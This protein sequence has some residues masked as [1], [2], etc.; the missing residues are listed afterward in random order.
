MNRK[1]IILVSI[2][3]CTA[4]AI[5]IATLLTAILLY[6]HIKI[7]ITT[8]NKKT[9]KDALINGEPI[10]ELMLLAEESKL[11]LGDVYNGLT[12]IQKEK[13]AKNL[14]GIN[15]T[16]SKNS[17]IKSRNINDDLN[18]IKDTSKISSDLMHKTYMQSFIQTSDI[19]N[20]EALLQGF[21][22]LVDTQEIS[23]LQSSS[24]EIK[25]QM[26]THLGE[27]KELQSIK[28]PTKENNQTQIML[29]STKLFYNTLRHTLT[30][31]LDTERTEYA[32][33]NKASLENETPPNNETTPSKGETPPNNETSPSEGET[34]PNNETTPSKGETPPNNETTPSKGETPPNNE[35]SPSEGETPPN[36]ETTPSKGETPPNNETSPSEGETPPNNETS[37]LKGKTTLDDYTP[38]HKLL[39]TANVNSNNI[40]IIFKIFFPDNYDKILK[41]LSSSRADVPAITKAEYLEINNQIPTDIIAGLYPT[42]KDDIIK[43]LQFL[44]QD[45]KDKELLSEMVVKLLKNCNIMS[46]PAIIEIITESGLDKDP[47]AAGII[48]CRIIGYLTDNANGRNNPKNTPRMYLVAVSRLLNRRSTKELDINEPVTYED[49]CKMLQNYRST[50]I[51]AEVFTD[52]LI[53]LI[54]K[55]LA[56]KQPL[57]NTSAKTKQ[58]NSSRKSE[59][60]SQK[61][62]H[63]AITMTIKLLKRPHIND[64]NIEALKEITK[65]FY[66]FASESE[67]IE[68]FISIIEAVFHS[69]INQDIILRDSNNARDS[70]NADEIS[71]SLEHLEHL[72]IDL[73]DRNTTEELF[74]HLL[75]LLFVCPTNSAKLNKIKE[76]I[77]KNQVTLIF[78]FTAL[79]QNKLSYDSVRRKEEITLPV[80]MDQ[81][82]QQ[83]IEILSQ[84]DP[85]F[86]LDLLFGILRTLPKNTSEILEENQIVLILFQVMKQAILKPETLVKNNKKNIRTSNI[87]AYIIDRLSNSIHEEI[88]NNEISSGNQYL[89]M[90]LLPLEDRLNLLGNIGSMMRRDKECKSYNAILENTIISIASHIGYRT[91]DPDI[92]ELLKIDK[93]NDVNDVNAVND[94]ND[95]NA[96]NDIIQAIIFLLN[97]HTKS[98]QE[99]GVDTSKNYL[100]PKKSLYILML[101]CAHTLTESANINM[102]AG[103]IADNNANPY[104]DSLKGYDTI[105]KV[106]KYEVIYELIREESLKKQFKGIYSYPSKLMPK[107]ITDLK[108]HK[109]TRDIIGKILTEFIKESTAY[110]IKWIHTLIKEHT[111]NHKTEILLQSILKTIINSGS[112]TDE[113]IDNISSLIKAC[114]TSVQE[115]LFSY[116]IAEINK[117]HLDSNLHYITKIISIFVEQNEKF[118]IDQFKKNIQTQ[119]NTETPDEIANNSTLYSC[120]ISLPIT[121]VA[122][123]IDPDILTANHLCS[124][125]FTEY[126]NDCKRNIALTGTVLMPNTDASNDLFK[127]KELFLILNDKTSSLLTSKVD[128][129]TTD[130]KQ[131][132]NQ[133]TQQ[134][135]EALFRL[136]ELAKGSNKDQTLE[137]INTNYIIIQLYTI[138]PNHDCSYELLYSIIKISNEFLEKTLLIPACKE[139]INNADKDSQITYKEQIILKIFD[140]IKNS[141][142]QANEK[143]KLYSLFFDLW[144]N[145]KD[146]Q[147]KKLIIKLA[148]ENNISSYLKNNESTGNRIRKLLIKESL[149]LCIEYT[150]KDEEDTKRQAKQFVQCITKIIIPAQEP[151]T[152]LETPSIQLDKTSNCLEDYKMLAITNFAGHYIL[153]T[154]RF[155][156]TPSYNAINFLK[157]SS[158]ELSECT[159]IDNP[160]KKLDPKTRHD[161]AES[162]LLNQFHTAEELSESLEFI[163]EHLLY[164]DE[165]VQL[166]TAN[167]SML[168][169]LIKAL[170]AYKIDIKDFMNV[171]KKRFSTGINLPDDISAQF[172]KFES[173]IP[174]NDPTLRNRL[175]SLSPQDNVTQLNTN[176]SVEST[177]ETT[178]EVVHAT[179]ANIEDHHHNM[180]RKIDDSSLISDTNMLSSFLK[181]ILYGDKYNKEYESYQD[182][183]SRDK[184]STMMNQAYLEF[185]IEILHTREINTVA[186]EQITVLV[187][188]K[189]IQYIVE[190]LKKNGIPHYTGLMEIK[191]LFPNII[192]Y[193]Y[194]KN[195]QPRITLYLNNCEITEHHTQGM[196]SSACDIV[197]EQQHKHWY[198]QNKS[199]YYNL[200]RLLFNALGIDS[201]EL[202]QSFRQEL[203]EADNTIPITDITVILQ[204]LLDRND[205]DSLTND[206]IAILRQFICS[207]STSK[208]EIK[209][210][211]QAMLIQY[212]QYTQK[213]YVI[214]RENGPQ[215]QKTCHRLKHVSHLIRHH[216]VSGSNISNPNNP[217]SYY[218]LAQEQSSHRV[219]DISKKNA[220]DSKDGSSKDGHY[221][222]SLSDKASGLISTRINTIF[223]NKKRSNDP[224][225][226]SAL[227]RIMCSFY[228]E[229][230]VYA[231]ASI[232]N[233]LSNFFR[234][235]SEPQTSLQ[236]LSSS[237]T[238]TM[239]DF[240]G[241][242]FEK[243]SGELQVM[244][245]LH[246]EDSILKII[247]DLHNQVGN[248]EKYRYAWTKGNISNEL[249]KSFASR[250][251]S[252]FLCVK[253]C[254]KIE[255][256][257]ISGNYLIHAIAALGLEHFMD[258]MIYELTLELISGI[259]QRYVSDCQHLNHYNIESVQELNEKLISNTGNKSLLRPKELSSIATKV[260]EWR[261]HN[262]VPRSPFKTHNILVKSILH[263]I[264]ENA[265][266]IDTDTITIEGKCYKVDNFFENRYGYKVID[267]LR[268]LP[269]GMLVGLLS[270]ISKYGYCANEVKKYYI[271][272]L[273]CFL[274]QLTDSYINLYQDPLTRVAYIKLIPER[275]RC[276]YQ[277]ITEKLSEQL[278]ILEL[279]PF[280]ECRDKKK[281][282]TIQNYIDHQTKQMR[283]SLLEQQKRKRV[284]ALKN[285]KIAII[286][287]LQENPDSSGL[288]TSNLR[289]L[290][291]KKQ[292]ALKTANIA[293]IIEYTVNKEPLSSQSKY[294]LTVEDLDR[295]RHA[296]YF[297]D[298]PESTIKAISTILDH[299]NKHR[300]IFFCQLRTCIDKRND[301]E[302]PQMQSRNMSFLLSH[303]TYD[304]VLKV[305]KG[306]NPRLSRMWF[307]FFEKVLASKTHSRDFVRYLNKFIG[308]ITIVE[309]CTNIK[310]EEDSS[311][312]EK[313]KELMQSIL[314]NSVEHG[315]AILEDSLE[316]IKQFQSRIPEEKANVLY[317]QV[318]L[319]LTDPIVERR[320]DGT[321]YISK[322][323]SHAMSKKIFIVHKDMALKLSDLYRSHSQDGVPTT[324]NLIGLAEGEITVNQTHIKEFKFN[325]AQHEL[326]GEYY[327]TALKAMFLRYTGSIIHVTKVL[328]FFDLFSILSQENHQ[329]LCDKLFSG[330]QPLPD[331]MKEWQ[332]RYLH[333]KIM[334]PGDNLIN[335]QMLF[336]FT[337]LIVLIIANN[338]RLYHLNNDFILSESFLLK[339][340]LLLPVQQEAIMKHLERKLLNDP[341]MTL[342]YI[343]NLLDT[344]TNRDY[345]HH[346]YDTQEEA[347][348]KERSVE[349][350]QSELEIEEGSFDKELQQKQI[351]NHIK[352]FIWK[353]PENSVQH[354]VEVIT[355]KS[356]C[357]KIS[358][359]LNMVILKKPIEVLNILAMIKKS[360]LQYPQ[361]LDFIEKTI[362]AILIRREI[363]RCGVITVA[364]QERLDAKIKELNKLIDEESGNRGVNFTE[365][366][367]LNDL[368][369][370]TRVYSENTLN[371]KSPKDLIYW[372]LIYDAHNSI[373]VDSN[374]S[375]RISD[376][377]LRTFFTRALQDKQNSIS[378]DL[379]ANGRY[380]AEK[381][382]MIAFLKSLVNITAEHEPENQETQ[383][384]F[385]FGGGFGGGLGS[386]EIQDNEPQ[387]LKATELLIKNASYIVRDTEEVSKD[388]SPKLESIEDAN[389]TID[390]F[391]TIDAKTLSKE[392]HDPLHKMY[393]Q[394]HDYY[395]QEEIYK[396]DS[397]ALKNKIE[398]I[399]EKL[400]KC[401]K[402]PLQIEITKAQTALQIKLKVLQD[403]EKKALDAVKEPKED[404]TLFQQISDIKNEYA[405]KQ[406][407]AQE[408][409]RQHL[410]K[411]SSNSLDGE[412]KL[413][414]QIQMLACMI[415]WLHSKS[416]LPIPIKLRVEQVLEILYTLSTGNVSN[417]ISQVSTG[418]GKSAIIAVLSAI[419]ALGG[420]KIFNITNNNTLAIEGAINFTEFFTS[421]GL[422]VSSIDSIKETSSYDGDIVYTSMDLFIGDAM[423]DHNG[424]NKL[425][426][427]FN[428]SEDTKPA[429][430]IIDEYDEV[431]IDKDHHSCSRLSVSSHD[432]KLS[433]GKKAV[434][435]ALIKFVISRHYSDYVNENYSILASKGHGTLPE[436]LNADQKEIAKGILQQGF[437]TE[438]SMHD[439]LK[440]WCTL[441]A[442]NDQEAIEELKSM[443][444]DQLAHLLKAAHRALLLRRNY[445]YVITKSNS[446]TQDSTS[447]EDEILHKICVISQRGRMDIRSTFSL[448]VHSMLSIIVNMTA[449]NTFNVEVMEE[450]PVIDITTAQ[451][452]L[453]QILSKGNSRMNCFSGTI[454]KSSETTGLRGSLNVDFT[455]IT[456]RHYEPQLQESPVIIESDNQSAMEKIY[457]IAR[458]EIENGNSVLI[459]SHSIEL[460]SYIERF[461]RTRSINTLSITDTE[462]TKELSKAQT[463]LQAIKSLES[464]PQVLSATRAIGRGTDIKMRDGMQL[465]VINT[466]IMLS[467][468][469]EKQ[470]KGRTARN[471]RQGKY[472]CVFSIEE[473]DSCNKDL[474][475][476][477][478][479]I[480]RDANIK[481]E[482]MISDKGTNKETQQSLLKKRDASIQD[483]INKLM[484]GIHQQMSLNTD[485][486]NTNVYAITQEFT[487]EYLVKYQELRIN[488]VN[489]ISSATD[490]SCCV[491]DVSELKTL[492]ERLD[493]FINKC[494]NDVQIIINIASTD[495]CDAL[496]NKVKA[497]F[498]EHQETFLQLNDDFG[499]IM[500]NTP[501]LSNSKANS[502]DPE[503][504]PPA[505]NTH[506]SI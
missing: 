499:S 32:E 413:S 324:N 337:R 100:T 87:R 241:L 175:L 308:F 378:C 286:L 258:Y 405:K 281:H 262:I 476:K 470:L 233:N 483:K 166:D 151:R 325:R 409:H 121:I 91:H 236:E 490:V 152:N 163:N 309:H 268:S 275:Y 33:A 216:N 138:V 287:A 448:S 202:L 374:E 329:S 333:N 27:N 158:K 149:E 167:E 140:F 198:D 298:S 288:S 34:P 344:L 193:Y 196:S 449:G 248:Y 217:L 238:S 137:I 369:Q 218:S 36:N 206:N 497:Q 224:L 439:A 312:A 345:F 386:S 72:L 83:T 461:L 97:N 105:T 452:T 418:E 111:N 159:K 118:I 340:I 64:P 347:E 444:K 142:V 9:L 410:L 181:K 303:P 18:T 426:K 441:S 162:I 501:H 1:I 311:K 456:P 259:K 125:C 188:Q 132:K 390:K 304:N 283:D 120:I 53:R 195:G 349:K 427:Y 348:L 314:N 484:Q 273:D 479:S 370:D 11:E 330:N 341:E 342:D 406:L 371:I 14:L 200:Y 179:T 194:R 26:V 373:E 178:V 367:T 92:R 469:E 473:L 184:A 85:V 38:V 372:S 494:I 212:T 265:K 472:C 164:Q 425:L 115:N 313:I 290:E 414:L 331:G 404:R 86:I 432:R 2:L 504:Q 122:K 363:L 292:Q 117:R 153:Y 263:T 407:E 110:Y 442:W 389:S 134:L 229:S 37:P 434:Y 47:A 55:D 318:I 234:I 223:N 155:S 42:S 480:R 19:K 89:L 466:D 455:H 201:T 353:L 459:H 350:I 204:Q 335:N 440:T 436:G 279:P 148:E 257:Q 431:L 107:I 66:T 230:G 177:T 445:D 360:G 112:C 385:G 109:D 250:I 30:L 276:C 207:E 339:F 141:K 393:K 39:N 460:A 301:I 43:L 56:I 45:I 416:P 183:H 8:D 463:E 323:Y 443:N 366:R 419:N 79:A 384:R 495:D 208:S 48:E 401:S 491:Y 124:Y 306:D 502:L 243:D 492:L 277:E 25:R 381:D 191:Q 293:K 57:Q 402:E 458:Q 225:E 81:D 299:K 260:T 486:H 253:D 172:T 214:S 228:T 428:H 506:K 203:E 474:A 51:G 54:T 338:Q 63:K 102:I 101:A 240:I 130:S 423:R 326:Y 278:T 352:K 147:I 170:L 190:Q 239:F 150:F 377:N 438:D 103:T 139:L 235:N 332:L 128:V 210:L 35:T 77:L 222:I 116:L 129:S 487:K 78:L 395:H 221:Y 251:L 417:T 359:K 252:I 156:Q 498:V 108:D 185:L 161:I 450:K 361:S 477:L 5:L 394:L 144:I 75:K 176:V 219:T 246:N 12:D 69:L 171:Y 13:T 310:I 226:F 220:L 422:S 503:L 364:I 145:Y 165:S 365:L 357:C 76:T 98:S 368:I 316:I 327:T 62:R 227:S 71:F 271:E 355:N 468:R 254:K 17:Q 187:S 46:Y 482:E 52:E 392:D 245:D 28:N 180:L 399:Q 44:T 300:D 315:I 362:E 485:K 488:I 291:E 334:Q 408:E 126:I 321:Y 61:Q 272:C 31:Q 154:S 415:E 475:K 174:L 412:A 317:E 157:A 242:L 446:N 113:C 10:S 58:S 420:E 173:E 127:L 447:E 136:P 343:N 454:G 59:L 213:K 437:P 274:M 396:L 382:N 320:S 160:L 285:F 247:Y 209:E 505:S 205:P 462:H 302:D 4:I 123:L 41:E 93:L 106:E 199:E 269:D 387:I 358:K 244:S 15:S 266:D 471:G 24:S 20:S 82:H 297:S 249:K 237:K 119:G 90:H 467:E 6:Q 99:Q 328:A 133:K 94:V 296:I 305:I 232:E 182:I 465:V 267:A 256:E 231:Q 131:L 346:Y 84:K 49:L 135:I 421:L 73:Y 168:A 192:F 379:L 400:Q 391:Q 60:E 65:R 29:A 284:V 88:A 7:P 261:R 336:A 16:K 211:L 264:V 40:P 74:I 500:S 23:F 186:D 3:C 451:A 433:P 398:E 270:V 453:S 282:G 424:S 376:M 481:P 435:T 68:E 478:T 146:P 95:V 143:S 255:A 411:L 295:F 189:C 403:E 351:N 215:I 104:Y 114:D 22:T 464:S 383:S 457:N 280:A 354:L 319:F 197:P 489:T 322:N 493:I 496:L 388:D 397:I 429:R 307:L 67:N 70:S 294:L 430:I 375:E 289:Q 96:V 169:I 50:T 80:Q 380:I 21:L 356:D